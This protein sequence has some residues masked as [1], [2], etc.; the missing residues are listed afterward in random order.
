M[1]HFF[2]FRLAKNLLISCLLAL[3]LTG[4]GGGSDDGN[5]DNTNAIFVNAG[6]DIQTVENTEVSISG[7]ASGQAETVVW[8]WSSSPQ[9]TI[10]HTDTAL[11]DAIFT[12]PSVTTD[13]TFVLTLTATN[14]SGSSDTDTVNVVVK[15]INVA[16]DAVITFEQESGQPDNTFS[17][18][19]TLVLSGSSSTDADAADSDNPIRSW[20]WQQTS[21]DSV[22]NNVVTNAASLSVVMPVEADGQ[23]I[24]L[25][26]TVT[27]GEGATDTELVTLFVLSESE[28]EP[29]ANAGVNQAVFSGE[30]IVLNGL[31]ETTVNAGL[32][33]NTRWDGTALTS[34]TIINA[35]DLS[36]YAIA[37][38]VTEETTITYTLDV[39]DS[40]GHL[41]SDDIEV[42]VRPFPIP[43]MNDTGVTV[44]ASNNAYANTQQ[45]DFPGQDGQ[46]GSDTVNAAG[47]FEKAGRGKA[48][49]DFTKLN[50]N[51]DEEDDTSQAW[52]CVRDNITGLVWEKKTDDGGLLDGENTYSWYFTDE[53]GGFAGTLNG[54]DAVCTLTNCNTEAYV[55]AVNS[56]GLC[57]FYDWR[58]PTHEELMSLLHFGLAS[59]VMLDEEYFPHAGS[60]NNLDKRLWYWTRIPSADGVSGDAA[61][62]AWA[63]DFASGLD[64]FLN[65][66]SAARI[67]LVR[68]GR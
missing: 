17:A 12:A 38:A 13:T 40:F 55:S 20:E 45:N 39:T 1:R 50:S 16:P 54:A 49:F 63:M 51:G 31:A 29:K 61:Q 21:G 58:V 59:G 65:K 52:S 41:V 5:S 11:A 19:S 33:L 3:F 10:T 56:A 37:P 25:T 27:D 43:L 48:G 44:Q 64:N 30:R 28:T 47:L 22:L 8:Q 14:S 57:G 26:L 53:N 34:G 6:A 68:A 60:V 18:G 2:I 62:N 4:C 67:R 35:S 15:P 23:S 46:R 32:P 66:S 9:A 36:T 42:K 7:Q 24:T